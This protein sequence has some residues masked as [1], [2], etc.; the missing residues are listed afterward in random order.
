[1]TPDLS[2]RIAAAFFAGRPTQAERD[3]LINAAAV[4]SVQSA[5]DLP[6]KAHSLLLALEARGAA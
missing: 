6:T 3:L 1:M 5:E 2:R 4:R